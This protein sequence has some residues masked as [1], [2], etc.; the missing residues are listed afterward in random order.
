MSKILVT[1]G[2]G[3]VGS[4]LVSELVSDGHTPLLLIRHGQEKSCIDRFGNQVTFVYLESIIEDAN[5]LNISTV[6]NLAG[7]Y[8]FKPNISQI[9]QMIE[10]NIALPSIIADCI[11]DG[12]HDV[13]WIQASTF[14]QHYDSAK[15][16]PTCFYA[17][18][19]QAGEVALDA[20]I[21][22][23][24]QVKT[25]V[26]PH[27]F[28]ENDERVKL[29]NYLIQQG[30][31]LSPIK[32][33]S[34]TQ[35]MDLVHVNDVVSAIKFALNPTLPC[36]R[37]Q[38]SSNKSITIKE[39]ISFISSQLETSLE[40]EYDS[41]KDRDRD[42]YK[43]WSCAQPLPNWSPSVDLYDWIKNQMIHSVG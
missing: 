12:D 15:Y 25:L 21:V 5:Q 13:T 31:K 3:F 27:I 35:I 14:M 4:R 18:T 40:V 23:G 28:G 6:V 2:M 43:I 26:L 16:D 8:W 33:S 41:S 34:G 11:T 30:L 10:S 36:G 39:I 38:I 9:R 1:G 29:L 37:Y 42:V 20:F 7:K 24:I 17:S 22:H 19:K 32:V